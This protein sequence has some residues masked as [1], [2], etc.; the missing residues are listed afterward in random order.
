MKSIITAA[1]LFLAVNVIHASRIDTVFIYSKSMDTTLLNLVI[2]PENAEK[3]KLPVVYLLHGAGGYA[4]KWLEEISS[5]TKL[6]DKYRLLLVIPDGGFTSWYFDSPVDT[7]VKYESYIINEVIPFVDSAYVTIPMPSK[8]AVTGYSM[9]GHGALYL[10]FRHPEIFG[11]CGSMSGAFDLCPYPER[12]EISKRL[13]PYETNRTSW[14]EH[15]VTNMTGLLSASKP[16]II[17]DCGTDD[18]FIDINRHFHN[19]LLSLNIPHDYI[20][21]PGTHDW[22]YWR[23]AIDYQILYFYLFFKN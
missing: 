8:R 10:S 12:W 1:L 21:R 5:V 2:V 20:E 9:G 16:C 11:A 18:L 7:K 19:K 22:N 13:G 23:N 3:E 14:F 4:L 6:S 15:S 17:F